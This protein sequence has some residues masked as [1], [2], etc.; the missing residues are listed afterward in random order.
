MVEAG[1]VGFLVYLP[2]VVAVP[3]PSCIL[4][5]VLLTICMYTDFHVGV[6]KSCSVKGFPRAYRDTNVTVRL[7]Q[8]Q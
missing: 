6:F 1:D 2:A 5:A 7:D 8:E 4:K 3:F